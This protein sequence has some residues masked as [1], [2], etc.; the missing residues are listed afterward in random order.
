ML[1]HQIKKVFNLCL[2][3]GHVFSSL[4]RL[5]NPRGFVLLFLPCAWGLLL[6]AAGKVLWFE[7]GL[8][9]LGAFL[10]R[11]V[12][13]AYNDW[14][15]RDIDA[16]VKRTQT[17]PLVK[18]DLPLLHIILASALLLGLA[19]FVLLQLSALAIYIGFLV[20]FLVLLYPWLKRVTHWPQLYLGFLFASGVWLS[21]FHLHDGFE[22]LTLSPFLLYAVGVLWTLYY[23]TL[24]GYQDW[25]D[26][27][28]MGLK[29]TAVLWQKRPKPFFVSLVLAMTA[30][31]VTLGCYERL[32]AFYYAGVGVTAIWLLWQIKRFDVHNARG[33][34]A[35]FL[36]N[37]W[38]GLW[39]TLTLYAGFNIW[40]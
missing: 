16:N 3:E 34:L 37:Q 22:D 2:H 40:L 28:K 20:A 23:D 7:M 10:T 4:F 36:E 25:E 5:Q 9:A 1:S 18:N 39:I 6:A 33:A 19:L 14:V 27:Q 38:V 13:C 35:L 31:L 24:Y 17:R 29:S 30:L 32:S 21:W 11:S 26:D 8:F 12:G 15:D